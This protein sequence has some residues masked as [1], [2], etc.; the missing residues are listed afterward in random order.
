MLQ[1]SRDRAIAEV[2]SSRTFKPPCA[3]LQWS[4]DRAIA[5]VSLSYPHLESRHWASMEPRSR[6]RGSY[7]PTVRAAESAPGLQWSRDRAIA[8]VSSMGMTMC[9]ASRLQ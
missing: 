2:T 4:R 1:W 8:E 5:E 7:P 3:A 9:L 6:D